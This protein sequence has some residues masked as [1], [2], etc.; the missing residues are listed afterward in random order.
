MRRMRPDEP[1]CFRSEPWVW[2]VSRR[3][4]CNQM[5]CA[6]QLGVVSSDEPTAEMVAAAAAAATAPD[7]PMDSP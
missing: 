2:P 7:W 1:V 4:V 3:R 5:K 6:L